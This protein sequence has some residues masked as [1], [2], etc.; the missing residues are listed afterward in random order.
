MADKQ[1][2]IVANCS[3][4]FGDRFSAAKEMVSGGP[5]DVLT[6]DYLAELTMA[7]LLRAKQK[8]PSGGYC[9]TFLKQMEQVMGPCLDKGV[10][11]VSNAGGLNPQGLAE[12]LIKVAAELGLHPKIAYITGDDLAPRLKDLQEQGEELAHLDTGLPLARSGAFPISANAYLGGWGV[13]AALAKGADIVVAGRLADAAVVM[14][15]AAWAFGWRQDDWDALAGAAVAGHIV[16]CG[17]QASGG[18][19][20]F[21]DEVPSFRRVGFPIAEIYPD[22]SSVI[23]KHPGTGGLVSLGTVTAQ[24][25]YEVRG[26]IYLTP[27]VGARFD[28][29]ELTQQGTD[30]VLVQGVKGLPAPETTKVCIN[31]FYG[32][33][34]TMTVLL[35][36]LDIEKKARIVEESLFDVLGPKESFAVCDVQLLRYDKADPPSNEEAWA[37]LRVSL[38]DP[39]KKKVGRAF[40]S[41][42]VELALANIPGFTLTSPPSDGSPAIQHWPALIGVDKISQHVFIDGQEIVV[43]AA[44]PRTPAKDVAAPAIDIPPA[45]GGKLVKA[46]LGRAFATRS[47]DKGGNANLGVWA[48]TPQAFAWLRQFLTTEKLGQLLPDCAGFATERYELPNL[49]ALNFYIKGLLGEGVAA[50]IKADPQAKTLGEYLRA[51]I[52]EMPESII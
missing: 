14:G 33:R 13:A 37:H 36:G 40:S 23:T 15:P 39:D 21:I 52:I 5:I 51:K 25:L 19:Y 26:P 4:F 48:R 50:S 44:G 42:V 28:T 29:I 20:S 6:G 11:V 31:N 47:G 35:T 34:N 32:H 45:P 49:L 24:L 3:G 41:A 16:E 2:L 18:N 8:D 7:I 46:P 1:K 27:D 9:S 38:M 43:P 17:C 10:K 30:R 12:A 22:G